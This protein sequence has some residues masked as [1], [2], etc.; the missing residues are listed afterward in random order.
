M[1]I[2]KY[3]MIRYIRFKIKK[4]FF[5]NYFIVYIK[6]LLGLGLE[7]EAKFIKE[8]YKFNTSIDIGSNTGHFSNMLRKISKKVYS[9]E[10]IIYLY[11]NQKYL[12]KNSNVTVFNI[13]LGS[14]KEK[15]KFY[16]PIHNDPEASLIKRENSIITTTSVD[17]GDRIFKNKKIDFIKIDVEGTELNVIL[18]LKKIIRKH[19]PI[20]MI[21]IE[22]R[23]N[24][25]YFKVFKYLVNLNY[26]I[27]YL[28]KKK[29][30]LSH[31]NLSNLNS[32]ININQ[33]NIN[34]KNYINN[35]FFKK[36]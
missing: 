16:I 8:K 3:Y 6:F 5:L 17:T 29:L 23:H 13:A 36:N 30:E 20:I 32:F 10:P 35:F 26:K 27:Y 19:K 28:D 1:V 7:I 12:F 2:I 31:L 24:L 15:K 14:K 9:F 21:E 11:K 4:N 34:S 18:G 22:K 33:K 25:K